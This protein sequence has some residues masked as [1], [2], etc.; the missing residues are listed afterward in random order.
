MKITIYGWS[1]SQDLDWAELDK[2]SLSV[3]AP[4]RDD[5]VLQ[6]PKPQIAPSARILWLAA[7][8]RNLVP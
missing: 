3:W 2:T 8:E 1:T 6:S 7:E 5:A 4:R